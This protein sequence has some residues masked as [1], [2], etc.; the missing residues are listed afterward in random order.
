MVSINMLTEYLNYPVISAPENRHMRFDL[1][2]PIS[3]VDCDEDLLPNE[4]RYGEAF[5]PLF[6]GSVE[7]ASAFLDTHENVYV[8]ALRRTDEN[9]SSLMRHADRAI[10]CSTDDELNTCFT[11]ANACFMITNAWNLQLKDLVLQGGNYQQFVDCSEHV[12][13]NFL[14]LTDS[15]F[16]L[17]ASSKTLSIDDEEILYLIENGQHSIKA[18]EHFRA[19]NLMEHW[20]KQTSIELKPSSSIN[21]YPTLD[22]V[23]STDDAYSLHLNLHCNRTPPTPGLVDTLQIFIDSMSYCVQRHWEDSIPARQEVASLFDQLLQSKNGFLSVAV[24]ALCDHLEVPVEGTFRLYAWLFSTNPSER[25]YDPYHI[26]FLHETFPQCHICE[27]DQYILM[28]DTTDTV[29]DEHR[30]ALDTFLSQHSSMVGVSCSFTSIGE[31]V[32]AF[33]QATLAI[34]LTTNP[35]RNMALFFNQEYSNP[36]QKFDDHLL[37]YVVKTAR[38]ND[39]LISFSARGSIVE[40]IADYDKEHGT[41]DLKVLYHYMASNCRASIACEE[42]YMHRS[43]L[44]YRINKMQERFGFDLDD[45]TTRLKITLGFLIIQQDEE[46]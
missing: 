44:L 32:Q 35:D 1:I 21:Q 18:I 20:T 26:R 40:Q 39:P 7:Q 14:T 38:E 6:L 5:K 11:K 27:H 41:E 10:I 17:V 45:Y 46:I 9:I 19:L 12:L 23:F 28:L 13:G 3:F 24:K 31:F 2:E 42:L 29:L 4:E 8:M 22:Y 33:Q 34:R 25:A 16:N 36:L 15:E 37:E 30:E 43:T